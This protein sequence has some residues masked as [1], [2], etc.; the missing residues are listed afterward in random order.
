MDM[1]YKEKF[2]ECLK[3]TVSQTPHLKALKST[4]AISKQD[5]N[6]ILHKF[7]IAQGVDLDILSDNQQLRVVQTMMAFTFA[8]RFEKDDNFIVESIKDG[9]IEFSVIRDTMYMYSKRAKDAFFSRPIETYFFLKFATSIQF[10]L[11]IDNRD[12]KERLQKENQILIQ[13]GVQSLE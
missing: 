9:N 1:Y 6:G 11:A 7:I 8:H 10:Q 4:A 2:Q 12:A 3:Q 13:A 5:M